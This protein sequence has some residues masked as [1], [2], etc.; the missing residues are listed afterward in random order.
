MVGRPRTPIGTSGAVSTRR[1][2]K[3]VMAE[4]RF[5]DADG[6]LRRVSTSAPSAA[7]ARR[8][9][10]EKLLSRPGYGNRGQLHPSSSFAELADLWLADLELRELAEGTRHGYRERFRLH[11][12]PAF[13]HYTLAEVTTG[14]VEW[15][16][17]AQSSYSNARGRQSRTLLNLVFGFALRHEAVGRNPVTGTSPLPKA[18]FSPQSAHLGS[19]SRDPRSAKPRRPGAAGRACLAPRAM[20]RSATSLRCCWA[21]RC[22]PEKRL[23]YDVVTSRTDPRG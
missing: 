9:L 17:K 6:W 20:A 11:V 3:S 4:A 7:A 10:S 22:G 23:P 2:G 15:F 13:E 16:L 18:K 14:R 5:R 12:R 1:R 8:R 21:R 19:D